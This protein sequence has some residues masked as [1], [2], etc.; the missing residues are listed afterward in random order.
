MMNKKQVV[1]FASVAVVLIIG[2]LRV[3]GQEKRDSLREKRITIQMTN[4]RV[5]DVFLR[6][7]YVYDIPIGF[8]ES[9]L[10]KDHSDYFFQTLM[11]PEGKKKDFSDEPQR[12]SGSSPSSRWMIKDKGHLISL[13]F[14]DARLDDVLD[15]IV[16]Q[17]QNYDWTINDDVV[18]IFPIKGRDPKFEKLLD[19]K[20]RGFGMS[21]GEQFSTIQPTIVI[22]LPEFKTFLAEN[23]LHS[24]SDRYIPS[25]ADLPLPMEL[26]FTDLTFKELLNGIT[27]LKRGG[28]ILRTD[29]HKGKPVEPGNEGKQIIEILI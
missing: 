13:D 12:M 28:W 5:F 10:D 9:V 16:K 4:E 8:E 1:F 19:L 21:K 14:R 2:L 7:M 3:N 23:K 15:E 25:Y 6:L 22:N 27:K 11:P 17:M 18:N 20:I 29:K 24:E 26:R